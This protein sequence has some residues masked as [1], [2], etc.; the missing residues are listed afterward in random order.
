MI[1][2][3]IFFDEAVR[4][5]IRTYENMQNATGHEDDYTTGCSLSY[6][7]FKEDYTMVA[8]NLSKQ[9]SLDADPIGKLDQAEGAWVVFILEEV[10]ETILDF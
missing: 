9:Q 4:N 8:I 3:R 10:K 1:D 5:D 2:G 7:Y 6:L